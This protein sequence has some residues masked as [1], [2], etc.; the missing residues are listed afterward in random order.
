MIDQKMDQKTLQTWVETVS[1]QFFQRPF[2]HQ[3]RF[4]ARL[5]ACGGRYL[6]KCG[7]IEISLNHWEAYGEEEVLGIIK[8]EL[9]HYHLHQ[10]KLPFGHRDVAFKKLL[11]EVGAARYCRRLPD[12]NKKK[13]LKPRR[14]EP[15]RYRVICNGCARQSLRKRFFQVARYRCGICR[16][17]LRLEGI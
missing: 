17:T 4:N 8:H 11:A 13:L 2:L 6:P 14:P 1:E 10:Q 15:Y 12:R 7:S 16:G 3:A 9:C 5:K